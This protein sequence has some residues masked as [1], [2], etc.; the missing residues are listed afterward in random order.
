M[1]E[2]CDNTLLQHLK[3]FLGT[4]NQ[5]I[6]RGSKINKLKNCNPWY[7]KKSNLQQIKKKIKITIGLDK[8]WIQILKQSGK[9]D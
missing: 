4:L 7:K 8:K 3:P 6:E 5:P 2:K 1:R 9:R